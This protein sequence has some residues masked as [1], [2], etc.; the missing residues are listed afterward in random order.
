MQ[1]AFYNVQGMV[2]EYS[3]EWLLMTSSTWKKLIENKE[4]TVTASRWF[5]IPQTAIWSDRD[6][7]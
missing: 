2:V 5:C 1:H 4:S 6:D 3:R 7:Y